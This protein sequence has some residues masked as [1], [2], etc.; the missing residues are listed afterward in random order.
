MS[1][2]V[3]NRFLQD[4]STLLPFRLAL[5]FYLDQSKSPNLIEENISKDAKQII[6]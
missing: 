3:D 5:C 1:G 2:L 4:K 6:K